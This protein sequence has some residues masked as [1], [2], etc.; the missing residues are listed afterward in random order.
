MK[1]NL[2]MREKQNADKGEVW[3]GRSGRIKKN[4]GNK[5]D[6]KEEQT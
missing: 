3:K 6:M 2:Q 1:I 4:N 5:E